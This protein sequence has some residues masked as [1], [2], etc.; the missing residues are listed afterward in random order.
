MRKNQS[1]FIPH[2]LYFLV[3]FYTHICDFFNMMKAVFLDTHSLGP[4]I[5]FKL[6]EELDFEWTL[7]PETDKAQTLSRVQEASVI[8]TNKV[9]I[10]REI[11]AACPNLKLV[12]IAATGYNNI[13]LAA[14]KEL[15]IRACNVPGYSTAS[16]VQLT[17]ALMLAL[18]TNL[19][20]YSETTKAGKWQRS[21][22][23]CILDEPIIELAGKKL[24][25]IGY[26]TLGKQVAQVAAAIG[27]H[28]L[29]AEHADSSKH[30]PGALPL[31]TVLKE[32][33]VVT[34][35]T[36]LTPK[37][38]NLIG[39]EQLRLMKPSAFLINTARGGIVNEKDLADCLK[40]QVIAGAGLD[41]LSVEPPHA[42]NPLLQKDVPHLLLTPHVGWGSFEARTRLVEMVK[43]NIYSFF[44]HTPKNLL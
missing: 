27:M 42:D 28:I 23:F 33:D 44:S 1:Q 29:I 36:P 17:V 8:A 41:V 4:G 22:Q 3:S 26:G 7:Y 9:K 25:I 12:C 37:T 16:V 40:Q 32:A 24:G 38:H 30:I 34:I 31:N 14:A 5:S 18:A 10:T 39:F 21:S 19:V 43:D 6:L 35:H 15:G 2:R 20:A 11:M 13:D